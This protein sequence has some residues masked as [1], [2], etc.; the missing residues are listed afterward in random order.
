[1]EKEQKIIFD[2][3]GLKVGDTVEFVLT[4]NDGPVGETFEKKNSYPITEL[5]Q[6]DG[7]SSIKI[8]FANRFD[9]IVF[10]TADEKFTQLKE[11][12]TLN[13]SFSWSRVFG[14]YI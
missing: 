11:N 9:L 6:N 5:T 4:F 2:K 1:M 7:S 3:I 10:E 13:L 14:S 12:K 8:R